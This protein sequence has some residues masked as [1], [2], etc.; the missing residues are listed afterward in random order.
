MR[1]PI[2]QTDGEIDRAAR[3]YSRDTLDGTFVVTRPAI[4]SHDPYRT[5]DPWLDERKADLARFVPAWI[6]CAHLDRFALIGA[7][8]AICFCLFRPH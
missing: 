5:P 8:A 2:V 1:R 7:L 6:E 4:R 3:R